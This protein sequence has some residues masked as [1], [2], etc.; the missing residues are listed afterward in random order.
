MEM[1]LVFLAPVTDGDQLTKHNNKL[2]ICFKDF[3]KKSAL[4]FVTIFTSST[5]FLLL[6]WTLSN[7]SSP[8]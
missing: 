6:F 4:L 5:V 3:L 1:A 2:R 7:I 8:V